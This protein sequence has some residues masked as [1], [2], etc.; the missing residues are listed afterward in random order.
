MPGLVRIVNQGASVFVLRRDALLAARG[1]IVAMTEDHCQVASDWCEQVLKA[2]TTHPELDGVGGSVDNGSR[3][4]LIDWANF[5]ITFVPFMEPF[6]VDRGTRLPTPANVSYKRR[7]IPESLD[8]GQL[9]VGIPLELDR[10][11]ALGVDPSVRVTHVQ[12]HGF[13]GSFAAHFHN[14]RATTGLAST[15]SWKGLWRSFAEMV[16]ASVRGVWRRRDGLP[17]RALLSLPLVVA[18]ALSHLFGSAIGLLRGP[19]CSPHRLS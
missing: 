11:R 7:V 10:R 2:H 8:V 18:L 16:G 17:R 1:P 15:K 14:G 9:E 5:L 4:R 12:S 3:E 13:L 19:G 6:V